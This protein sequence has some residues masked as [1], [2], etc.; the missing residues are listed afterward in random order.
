MS[1]L[2]FMNG[3]CVRCPATAFNVGLLCYNG[4]LMYRG[5][6]IQKEREDRTFPHPSA[7]SVTPSTCPLAYMTASWQTVTMY[8]AL[9]G[10]TETIQQPGPVYSN[11]TP[12]TQPL[13]RFLSAAGPTLTFLPLSPVFLPQFS[14]RL[15]EDVDEGGDLELGRGLQGLR[16][17]DPSAGEASPSPGL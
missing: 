1:G 5:V 12:I 9:E 13:G 3:E 11:S 16:S 10:W 14:V 7:R 4:G 15:R 17:A 2:R 8:R 6:L